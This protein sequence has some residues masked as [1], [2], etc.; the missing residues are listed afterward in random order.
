MVPDTPT[1][2]KEVIT[3]EDDLGS[4]PGISIEAPDEESKPVLEVSVAKVVPSVPV[5]LAAP[6]K[7]DQEIARWGGRPECAC[8]PA[9]SEPPNRTSCQGRPECAFDPGNCN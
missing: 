1:R 8:D 3:V 2:E 4:E 5:T 9:G 6:V 7:R